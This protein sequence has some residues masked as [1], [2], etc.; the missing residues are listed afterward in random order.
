MS[1][2]TRNG[3]ITQANVIKNET[4]EGAN[5]HTRVGKQ[6]VDTVDTMYGLYARL[7]ANG[8]VNINY[9]ISGYD[10]SDVQ[11]Q[12]VKWNRRKKCWKF[13]SGAGIPNT[14]CSNKFISIDNARTARPRAT[15][16]YNSGSLSFGT[17]Q[18][19]EIT[20]ILNEMAKLR[21]SEYFAHEISNGRHIWYNA[22]RGGKYFNCEYAHYTESHMTSPRY[23]VA[24]TYKGMIISN[25]IAV[26]IGY[27]PELAKMLMRIVKK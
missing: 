11:L 22:D 25:V 6:L 3:L 18:S 20:T 21:T 14:T 13:V 23:G 2:L 17:I 4:N 19:D 26:K 15:F 5:T 10:L 12:V 7:D 27:C 8:D 24:V 9:T 16:T 1:I